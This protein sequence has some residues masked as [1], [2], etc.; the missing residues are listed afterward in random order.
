ME[1]LTVCD[2]VAFDVLVWA[3]NLVG[4]EYSRLDLRVVC[5]VDGSAMIKESFAEVGAGT[6]I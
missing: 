5:N 1:W 3:K 4:W 2:L 6:D